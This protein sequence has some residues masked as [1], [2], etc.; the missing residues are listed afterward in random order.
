MPTDTRTPDEIE[1]D[2]ER[3]RSELS[4]TVDALQDKFSLD[5][6]LR[7]VT[8]GF[9]RHGGDFGTAISRSAKQ[10]PVALAV[11]G[12]GLA[13]LMFGRS[14]DDPDDFGPAGGNRPATGRNWDDDASYGSSYR[15]T[16]GGDLGATSSGY[17]GPGSPARGTFGSRD[18]AYPDWARHDLDD[19]E[20]SRDDGDNRSMGTRASET[21]H[22]GA[23]SASAGAKGAA[24]KVSA[25]AKSAAGAVSSRASAASEGAGRAAQGASDRI[26]RARERLSRGTEDMSEG[27]RERIIAARVRAVEMAQKADASARKNYARGRDAAADFIEEQ[28]LVA[29]AVAMAV[30]AALAGA[31][32]R[33]R[34]E[35]EALGEARDDLFD[36]A[37]RIFNHER[38][39]AQNVAKAAVDEAGNI[40][41]EKRDQAD[42]SAPGEKS[43]VDAAADEARDAGKRV[44]D[45][46]EG[47]A[48]K[49]GLGNPRS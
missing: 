44:R 29:G 42:Q 33:T 17:R 25:G 36:E 12:V 46:A 41:K 19:Y 37:E 24:D 23:A 48:K 2:L 13:W 40:A 11:T 38:R 7:E 8:G 26:K 6:I 4:H 47:E 49:E 14:H 34:R 32:P 16:R 10:N 45:A 39:K 35:D 9:R 43:A 3:E 30:G 27:A 28:P 21:V 20:T 15:P 18:P 5:A 1:R 31:L 22:E